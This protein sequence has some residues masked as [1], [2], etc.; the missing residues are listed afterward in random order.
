MTRWLLV[1]VLCLNAGLWWLA[2]QGRPSDRSGVVASGPLP[3]VSSLRVAAERPSAQGTMDCVR[4]G[5][6]DQ[7]DA[8]LA[9]AETVPLLAH[10]Q[11]E[12]QKV[13]R[14]RPPLYWVILPPRPH[15]QA[16]QD[17]RDIQRRGIDSYLVTEGEYRNAISLGLFESR[18]AAISVLEEKKRQNLNAVLANYQRNQISYALDFQAE[19]DLVERTVQAV[20]ADSGHDL[21]LVEIDPC[22]GV[23]T[24]DK[25]P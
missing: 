8:A 3:R 20:A 22:E 24:P 1:L 7:P 11:P 21:E 9:L 17:F 12:V 14:E 4:L 23:A 15:D 5:W 6:F 2:D 10:W 19:P 13:V 16:L 25:S 18:E